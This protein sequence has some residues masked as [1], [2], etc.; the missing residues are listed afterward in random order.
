[1]SEHE[2]NNI[3]QKINNVMQ[4]VKYVQKDATVQGYK[5]VTHD[6]VISVCRQALVDAGVMI[7]VCQDSG[8]LIQERGPEHKMHLYAGWYDISFVNVDIPSDTI[9]IR[10]NAH[11]ADTGDKAPG[12]ALSYAVKYAILKVLCLETGE[13]D[14]SR[15]EKYS[16]ITKAQVSQIE[17]LLD[18][19]SERLQAMLDHYELESIDQLP[20]I[21]YNAAIATLKRAKRGNN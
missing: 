9:T 17:K 15:A 7:Q 6:Q 2:G 1:M 13:N 5:A 19:D 16:P 14:E 11:A 10:I 8:S 4:R 21:D 3:Y 18:G 20:K 12:K